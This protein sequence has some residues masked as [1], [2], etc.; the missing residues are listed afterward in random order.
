M[1]CVCKSFTEEGNLLATNGEF[2]NAI[3][4]F[5]EA[6]KLYPGDQR[7]AHYNMLYLPS[8]WSVITGTTV[9]GHFVTIY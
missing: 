4:K 5:T 2:K 6:I 9:I 7:L 8:R 3:E 1:W